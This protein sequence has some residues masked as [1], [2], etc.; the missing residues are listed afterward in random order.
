[1]EILKF[2]NMEIPNLNGFELINW[3]YKNLIWLSEFSGKFPLLIE[4]IHFCI[5]NCGLGKGM[6]LCSILTYIENVR[7]P[8]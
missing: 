2:R 5:M 8:V 7:L 3:D 6:R 1:M 4:K